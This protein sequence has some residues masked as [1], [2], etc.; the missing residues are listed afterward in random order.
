MKSMATKYFLAAICMFM[1]GVAIGQTQ[2]PNTF[3]AGTP[4]KAAEVNANFAAVATAANDNAQNIADS[5]SVLANVSQN[6]SGNTQN[7]AANTQ[8]IESVS[9][10]VASIIAQPRFSFAG[11]STA[12]VDGGAGF[13]GM[14]ATCQADFGPD[15]RMAT[16]KEI[17]EST[18][19]P[20]LTATHAW[21][22]PLIIAAGAG[23]HDYSG[24]S[25][26]LS[27][28]TWSDANGTEG[29]GLTILPNGGFVKV[30]CDR[31]RP[32]ACSVLQ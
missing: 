22:Q 5:S 8:N 28:N 31:V 15:S 3:Q 24:L 26:P 18:I 21:V 23:S 12:Q 20:T 30:R 1:S 29:F 27:C 19:Q 16:S 14:A 6:V 13:F 11:F 9:Q 10:S 17:V 32:V 2:V 25:N 4:A 7:I